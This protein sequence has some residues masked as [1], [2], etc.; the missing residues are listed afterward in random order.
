MYL[1]QLFKKHW[2][3]GLIVLTTFA[4]C[5]VSLIGNYDEIADQSVQKIQNDVSSLI[6]KITKNLNA[7]D[8]QANAYANFK[9]D[10]SD[11]EGQVQSLQIRCKALPKYQTVTDQITS[12]DSTVFRLE[13]FHKLGFQASDTGSVRIINETLETDF[14]NIITLQNGL[15]LKSEKK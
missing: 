1:K 6:V 14:A 12:F 7:G 5:R 4:G 8:A 11:I 15:K 3:I 10:Y 9:N 2:L 13:Q